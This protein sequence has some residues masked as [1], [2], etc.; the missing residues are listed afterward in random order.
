M[1]ARKKTKAHKAQ[2]STMTANQVGKDK[3]PFISSEALLHFFK[4]QKTAVPVNGLGI[5]RKDKSSSVYSK[6]EREHAI[7]F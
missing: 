7:K 3:L 6:E 1:T 5:P 2:I 4:A